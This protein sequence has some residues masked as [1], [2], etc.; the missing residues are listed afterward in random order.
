L[1]PMT[2][3][4]DSLVW[5]LFLS[6]LLLVDPRS[7]DPLAVC[8]PLTLLSAFGLTLAHLLE[9]RK[10]CPFS[11]GDR[12]LVL[13]LLWMTL[14]ACRSPTPGAAS[15]RWVFCLLT[16]QAYLLGRRWGQ[17]PESLTFLARGSIVILVAAPWLFGHTWLRPSGLLLDHLVP[18]QALVS[19]LTNPDYTAG[20]LIMAIPVAAVGTWGFPFGALGVGALA[21]T[22]SRGGG[23]ALGVA[24]LVVYR[25]RLPA[26]RKILVVA[27]LLALILASVGV[28]RPE[29]VNKITNWATAAKRIHLWG[30]SA[31]LALL[32][33]WSG[34]GLGR[35][36]EL[37]SIHRPSDWDLSELPQATDWAHNF[38]LQV[39]VETGLSGLVPLMVL[40]LVFL[41]SARSARST[42]FSRPLTVAI[43]AFMLHNLVS[44]TAFVLPIA[45]F[46]SFC[47]GILGALDRSKKG[48]TGGDLAEAPNAPLS[49]RSG[50][51]FIRAVSVCLV[52]LAILDLLLFPWSLARH[53]ALHLA[54]QARDMLARGEYDRAR[55]IAAN[56]QSLAPL[57]SRIRYLLAASLS[58]SGEPIVALAHYLVL[59]SIECEYGQQS[60]NRGRVLLDA[61]RPQPAMVELH[62]FLSREPRS[63]EG[64][65][66]LAEALYLTGDIARSRIALARARALIDPK[67]PLAKRLDELDVRLSGLSPSRL[68]PSRPGIA[69]AR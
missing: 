35:F 12:A 34:A 45:L 59:E 7:I 14:V 56:A 29:G 61:E 24:F 53:Q 38:P 44:V 25:P 23:L 20:W 47:L 27:A 67:H 16:L 17:K 5:L 28:A 26:G 13:C 62:R 58:E 49:T 41:D 36:G 69:P 4:T 18:T 42:P 9:G 39:A 3:V 54:G 68:S 19:T 8:L 63:Y 21:L 60:Y 6:Q 33:F 64:H 37:Y 50:W 55:P 40:V 51:R 66:G 15:L 65:Y 11:W 46:A 2:L 52:V 30:V 10:P 43:L 1:D 48:M 57:D 22:L 31:K 32:S